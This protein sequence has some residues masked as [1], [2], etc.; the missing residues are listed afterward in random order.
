MAR[1]VGVVTGESGGEG[2]LVGDMA[3]ERWIQ[4]VGVLVWETTQGEDGELMGH[5][6]V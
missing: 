3:V 1:A 5:V 6:R 2:M 4:A